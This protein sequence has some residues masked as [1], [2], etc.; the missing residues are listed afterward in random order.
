MG[1]FNLIAKFESLQAQTA[2]YGE[3]IQCL[4]LHGF[5]ANDLQKITNGQPARIYEIELDVKEL[6][7]ASCGDL[8]CPTCFP[9]NVN[10]RHTWL[11]LML[12]P[13]QNSDSCFYPLFG[14]E[15]VTRFSIKRMRYHRSMDRFC[16]LPNIARQLG[17]ISGILPASLN[18][19]NL[20]YQFH[21]IYVG[22][23]MATCLVEE[24]RAGPT[25]FFDLG[26][27]TPLKKPDYP[28]YSGKLR[29]LLSKD[30][31][32]FFILSHWDSDHWRI[33]CWDNLLQS[34]L[35]WYAP[36]TNISDP[37]FL[38]PFLQSCLSSGKL[39][40]V[41]ASF[42]TSVSG[43]DG[44]ECYRH[45]HKGKKN[46]D[47]IYTILYLTKEGKRLQSLMTGDLP[48]S[49]VLAH[50]GVA[51]LNDKFNSVVVP[52]HGDGAS[53]LAVPLPALPKLSIAFFSAG[54]HAGYNHPRAAS[55]NAHT[56]KTYDVIN[57]RADIV[58][59]KRMLLDYVQL[60]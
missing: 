1:L 46:Y 35:Q 31:G 9:W 12:L 15:E 32:D 53:R 21:G 6:L 3:G 49:K 16:S 50:Q 60:L 2:N 58:A 48:Y 5:Q 43:A 19:G 59:G 24:K 40:L 34:K 52:H 4:R 20:R 47:G 18:S 57:C 7:K 29:A 23:G 45:I 13:S 27:G 39:K 11:A 28:R 38:D 33:F 26:G 10:R 44:F 37:K 17:A 8:R 51:H 25:I 36:D 30:G 22:Q 42:A 56:R 14:E 55:I 54:D 41:D